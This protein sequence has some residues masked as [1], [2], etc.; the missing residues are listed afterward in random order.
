VIIGALVGT[1]LGISRFT[2][3]GVKRALGSVLIIAGLKFSL[4]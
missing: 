1:R 4:F 3:V 2:S